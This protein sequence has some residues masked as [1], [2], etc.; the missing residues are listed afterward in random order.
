[1]MMILASLPFSKILISIGQFMMAGGWIVFWFDENEWLGRMR[2]K[3][4]G[5]HSAD[6]P[7][8]GLFT[9]FTG[10]WE[11]I[12]VLFQKQ[13]SPAVRLNLFTTPG[14]TAMDYRF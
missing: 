1:M 10:N 14:R 4:I 6:C 8:I 12:P 7:A 3:P 2:G 13:S 5:A 9:G 11:R